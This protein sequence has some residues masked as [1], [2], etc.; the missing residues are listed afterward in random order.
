MLTAL[1][2][3]LTPDA[4]PL[5]LDMLAEPLPDPAGG[6]PLLTTPV[7]AGFPAPADDQV[8]RRL[9]LDTHLIHNPE[10]TFFMRVQGDDL[11]EQGI[12]HGD[13]LVVDRTAA[14]S[15]GSLVVAE[16]AGAFAL[17]HVGRDTQGRRVLQSAHPEVPDRLLSGQPDGQIWG[18]VRWAVH[19]LWPGR[20]AS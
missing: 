2:K 5:W 15:T 8:E 11:H 9:H 6:W 20:L 13:L 18:V 7:P 1:A 3:R 12:H 17:W 4:F 16:I 19:R 14:A 10:D